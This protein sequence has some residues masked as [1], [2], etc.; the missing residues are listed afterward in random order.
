M[1]LSSF[2]MPK[3]SFEQV[4]VRL[5]YTFL[6]GAGDSAMF[7]KFVDAA[8]KHWPDDVSD[9]V[10][11]RA[12]I[13]AIEAKFAEIKSRS[14]LVDGSAFETA[15]VKTVLLIDELGALARNPHT[16]YSAVMSAVDAARGQRVAIITT[17]DTDPL[18]LRIDGRVF[19]SDRLVRQRLRHTLSCSL[20]GTPYRSTGSR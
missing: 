18:L 10:L 8:A 3:D 7:Q 15:K 11:L 5:L 4:A 16:S 1:H 12:V 13:E 19:G 17:L 2:V 14:Q 20:T 6:A 9:R